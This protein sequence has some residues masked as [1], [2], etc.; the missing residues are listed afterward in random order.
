MSS[1][2]HG[3]RVDCFR[4]GGQ[5]VMDT[6]QTDWVTDPIWFEWPS[7]NCDSLCGSGRAT[8]IV[9]ENHF[10]VSTQFKIPKNILCFLKL[11]IF[12]FL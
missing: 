9:T 12:S 2:I 6:A 3:G 7:G 1:V 10:Q 8:E 5:L 4:K 11:T